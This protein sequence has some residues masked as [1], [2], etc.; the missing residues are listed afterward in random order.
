[1][2]GKHRR[3][4]YF[5]STAPPLTFCISPVLR[6]TG[7]QLFLALVAFRMIL[8]HSPSAR[9]AVRP[10]LPPPIHVWV[11]RKRRPRHASVV[12]DRFAHLDEGLEVHLAATGVR[13]LAHGLGVGPFE[14]VER[15]GPLPVPEVVRVRSPPPLRRVQARHP[16]CAGRL[17]L[18]QRRPFGRLVGFRR[19]VVLGGRRRWPGTSRSRGRRVNRGE[20][21]GL[22]LEEREGH[23]AVGDADKA[24]TRAVG[25]EELQEER[26]HAPVGRSDETGT[27]PV[28]KRERVVEPGAEDDR[29][30]ARERLLHPTPAA[31]AGLSM[32]PF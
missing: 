17:R 23:D 1:M 21:E 19:P 10:V 18:E 5:F 29:V 13:F 3:C 9:K 12:V 30:D 8:I 26:V 11:T 16:G 15:V 6:T 24:Q 20:K 4:N 7:G 32:G 14:E 25:V 2:T 31:P 27:A 28:Q 22:V